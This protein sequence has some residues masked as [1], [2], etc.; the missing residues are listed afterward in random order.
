MQQQLETGTALVVVAVVAGEASVAVVV[1]AAVATVAAI[2][3][4]VA[5]VVRATVVVAVAPCL[6]C[7]E[8]S[9]C[10]KWAAA[11][12]A[13]DENGESVAVVVGFDCHH[14]CHCQS[15]VLRHFRNC[16]LECC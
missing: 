10:A 15:S 12:A 5:A 9:E 3:V 6:G 16:V 11:V 2:A 8:H 4:V 13:V 1:A 7:G 14:C